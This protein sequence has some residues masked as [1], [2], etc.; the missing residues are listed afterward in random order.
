MRSISYCPAPVEHIPDLMECGILGDYA[1]MCDEYPGAYEM[2]QILATMPYCDFSPP[3]DDFYFKD[4][5]I[6]SNWIIFFTCRPTDALRLAYVA[7]RLKYPITIKD[8]KGGILM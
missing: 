4:G 2:G 1:L 3:Q 5:I 8:Y 6:Y 7:N